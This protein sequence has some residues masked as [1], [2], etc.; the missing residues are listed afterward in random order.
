[1]I[2]EGSLK[3]GSNDT[4]AK[5]T[6]FAHFRNIIQPFT[7]RKRPGQLLRAPGPI[8]AS[9]M[10]YIWITACFAASHKRQQTAAECSSN[11]Y[12]GD[13]HDQIQFLLGHVSIQTTEQYLD[14]KQ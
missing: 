3:A 13:V 4:S 9:V 11:K 1:V 10:D 2:A 8:S 14:C 5:R 12:F 7:D 6:K